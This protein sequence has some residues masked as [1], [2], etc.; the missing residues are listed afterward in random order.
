[1]TTYSTI[2][3][4]SGNVWPI[5]R[6]NDGALYRHLRHTLGDVDASK[7]IKGAKELALTIKVLV[8]MGDREAVRRLVERINN[9]PAL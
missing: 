5:P 6:V 2:T 3:D 4:S 1:M 8:E 9:A 7:I